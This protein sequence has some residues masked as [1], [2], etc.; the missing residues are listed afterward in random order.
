MQKYENKEVTGSEYEKDFKDNYVP[1]A[2]KIYFLNTL[3]YSM[4]PINNDDNV[5]KTKVKG[6]YENLKKIRDEIKD[7]F[8]PIITRV[9]E[10]AASNPEA[11]RRLDVYNQA[12]K[13][14]LEMTEYSGNKLRSQRERDR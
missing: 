11:K 3:L 6:L 1:I 4:S 13:G 9:S 5:Q 14:L 12:I 10:R 2:K 7:V 8:G